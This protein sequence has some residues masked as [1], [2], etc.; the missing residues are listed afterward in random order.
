M[1]RTCSAYVLFPVWIAYYAVQRLAV[2]LHVHLKYPS[3][4]CDDLHVVVLSVCL[5]LFVWA[6]SF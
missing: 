2:L 3:L 6:T 4:K 1:K 5:R